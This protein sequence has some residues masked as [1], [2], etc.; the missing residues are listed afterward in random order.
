MISRRRLLQASALAGASLF[1]RSPLISRKAAEVNNFDGVI[2][3]DMLCTS[4]EITEEAVKNLVMAGMTAVVFDIPLYPREHEG[5]VREFTRLDKFFRE[6]PW[7]VSRVLNSADLA[8]A[9][10]SGK[11]GIIL[12]CQD[13]S[14]L[15]PAS[16]NFADN[17][18]VFYEFGLRVLQLTHN[19][20]TSYGDSFMELR[21]GGLSNAGREL[22]SSMNSI[23]VVIDLS[24][25]SK[26]TL[27]DAVAASPKPCAVTHA[28]C[29]ALAATARNKS[30]EEIKALASRGGVFGVYD[31][32]TWLTDKPSANLDTVLDHI[33]HAVHLVGPEHVGF[34]SDGALDQLDAD[35]ELKR[36]ARVQA[37]HA[38]GPSF[39]WPVRRVRIPELNS[40]SRINALADGLAKRG[41]S[42]ADIAGI[43]GGNFASL[44]QTVCG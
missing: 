27:L 43:V 20:R 40:A 36:M 21:D 9:K 28:G 1:S 17:L 25:C 23:G 30:D 41:Y 29:K 39:E 32:T 26:W 22:V 12:A 15:G 8:N 31:M 14:I 7:L 24:H 38:G 35:A 5:A 16:G 42:S 19:D 37:S 6:T 33:D 3:I 13:A 11:V 34:G 4:P 44:F 10:K 18:K 2:S